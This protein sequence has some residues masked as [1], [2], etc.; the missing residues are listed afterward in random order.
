ML[1]EHQKSAGQYK[2]SHL[3][4]EWN[5]KDETGQFPFSKASVHLRKPGLSIITGKGQSY[6]D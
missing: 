5:P 4:D 2:S 6:M 1:S 3:D